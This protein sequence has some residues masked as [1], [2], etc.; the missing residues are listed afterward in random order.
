MVTRHACVYPSALL[1]HFGLPCPAGTPTETYAAMFRDD[2]QGVLVPRCV[3][4][5]TLAAGKIVSPDV[6]AHSKGKVVPTAST[7]IHARPAACV[8]AYGFGQDTI[9]NSSSW[10]C[11]I[12][13]CGD[14]NSPVA[15]RSVGQVWRLR[16]CPNVTDCREPEA[17]KRSNVLQ[18][19]RDPIRHPMDNEK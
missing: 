6:E 19:F 3:I 18:G 17:G 12:N 9:F 13:L 8:V 4:R 14:D 1:C 5:W 7:N 10:R 11:P 2:C 15:L 16:H